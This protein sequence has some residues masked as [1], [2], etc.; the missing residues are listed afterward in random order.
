VQ[1]AGGVTNPTG[2]HGHRND[3]L[4]DVWG[5]TGIGIIEQK[6]AP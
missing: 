1:D 3:L 6:G 4:F 2:I 5:L